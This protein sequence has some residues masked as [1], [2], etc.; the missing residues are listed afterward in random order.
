MKVREREREGERERETQLKRERERERH[1]YHTQSSV[2][3]FFFLCLSLFFM[4][5]S[6]NAEKTSTHLRG[7]N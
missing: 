2:L 3:S 4:W 1:L 5:Y 6:G 7:E